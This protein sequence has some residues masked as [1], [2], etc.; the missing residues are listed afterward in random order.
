DG[1]PFLLNER[2][3]GAFLLCAVFAFCAWLYTEEREYVRDLPLDWFAAVAGWGGF[4]LIGTLE[5]FEHVSREWRLATGLVYAAVLSVLLERA[6]R[7]FA[8]WAA[9]LSASLLPLMALYFLAWLVQRDYQLAPNGLFAWA[10]AF[11]ALAWLV[12]VNETL[13]RRLLAGSGRGQRRGWRAGGGRGGG[14]CRAGWCGGLTGRR[15][16]GSAP[17]ARR[18]LRLPGWR[19]GCVRC[20]AGC[21][22]AAAA[23]ARLGQRAGTARR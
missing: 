6:A 22:R 10:P 7:R 16:W 20:A 23:G 15:E 3:I 17:A 11:A 8:P 21:T 9:A 14:L 19:A 12:H 1:S 5:L 18:G 4:L 13:R 2:F